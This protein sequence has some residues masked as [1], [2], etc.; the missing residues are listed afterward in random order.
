MRIENGGEGTEP[1]LLRFAYPNLGRGETR[2]AVRPGSADGAKRV[3]MNY[4]IEQKREASSVNYLYDSLISEGWK[5][6]IIAAAHI[7]DYVEI[8][9]GL[10]G[11][12]RIDLN[13]A[14]Y[15]FGVG[16]VI[17]INSQ[18]IH[19]ITAVAE[20][21]TRYIV[22]KVKP[23][24]L[25]GV[26]QTVREFQY[27]LPF[28]Q[29]NV[30]GRLI[31]KADVEASDA[32]RLFREIY[33]EMHERHYGYEMAMRAHIFALLLWLLRYWRDQGIDL[34]MQLD[35][36]PYTLQTLNIVFEYVE[37]RYSE[38]ICIAEI[39][40][41]C[42]MGQNAFSKFIKK[43]VHMTFVEYVNITRIKA[44]ER[45]LI[46]SSRSITEIAYDIG[47]SSTSYFIQRFK[48]YMGVTPLAFRK[49]FV[50]EEE[51]RDDI[52][53]GL[54]LAKDQ[55]DDATANSVYARIARTAQMGD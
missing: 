3:F 27:A 7:H 24:L 9:Y 17:V 52:A 40:K 25:Y 4:V 36:S 41:L 55:S 53:F 28:L 51:E 20:E 26:Q 45:M 39:A 47:Y 33:R 10:Q 54:P 8:L 49:R 48:A 5:N 42:G 38:D 11:E 1:T 50:G 31:R 12:C 29:Q 35:M 43:H 34:D 32:P 15:A 16:D 37:A 30:A 23:D 21:T 19:Q 22:V 44:A 46:F 13:D 2:S 18:V 6:K 14:T